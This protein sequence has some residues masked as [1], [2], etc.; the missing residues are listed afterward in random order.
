MAQKINIDLT[1]GLGD[2][3]NSSLM[4]SSETLALESDEARHRREIA[5]D[6]SKRRASAKYQEKKA[7]KRLDEGLVKG[8]T[9]RSIEAA[10]QLEA[11]REKLAALDAAEDAAKT[12]IDRLLEAV[13]IADT[14]PNDH[15]TAIAPDE[16]TSPIQPLPQSAAVPTQA[17]R[18]L[19][20][21]EVSALVG[22][23]RPEIARLMAALN[24]DTNVQLS[25]NDTSNLL[26][27]LL[28]CNETQLD[29]L[30]TNRKIP[31][32]IKIIIKR[33]LDDAKTGSTDT[34]ERLWDKIFGKNGL[35]TPEAAAQSAVES[36]IPDAPISR[37]AY[38]IL[39]QTLI[40]K[41]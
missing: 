22:T 37:E 6:I 30:Y 25:K 39:H 13:D 3:M 23:S 28:T 41:Q 29:A 34:V 10:E 2:S 38:A 40:C 26:A 17:R 32:A 7:L 11:A 16:I 20:K 14:Q 9:K 21:S 35:N 19:S 12:G 18:I 4:P 27:C 31:V 33:I 15:P 5:R 8:H 1:S 36:L 24:L